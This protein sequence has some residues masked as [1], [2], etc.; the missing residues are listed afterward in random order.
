MK[1]FS[2][3]PVGNFN[4]ID[5]NV[6]VFISNNSKHT[7]T[8]IIEGINESDQFIDGTPLTIHIAPGASFLRQF[9][10]SNIG[11]WEFQFGVD[12]CS[13]VLIS[14]F[15][16]EQDGSFN[17]SDRVLNSELTQI[18]RLILQPSRIVAMSFCEPRS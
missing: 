4:S 5:K 8:V 3:G 13:D 10:V 11:I 15:A 1:F 16:K 17:P 2:T 12:V 9:D 7:A 6:D 18:E 14:T